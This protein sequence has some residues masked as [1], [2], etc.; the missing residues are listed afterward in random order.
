M[1][2][3]LELVLERLDIGEKENHEL[4]QKLK[5]LEEDKM[6]L[7]LYFAEVVDDHKR[8]MEKKRLQLKRIRRYAINQEAWF[9]YAVGSFVTVVVIFIAIV[10][11]FRCTR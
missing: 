8:Q 9:H 7:D 4:K 2:I 3:D 6:I 11:L 5:K 10:I 1:P